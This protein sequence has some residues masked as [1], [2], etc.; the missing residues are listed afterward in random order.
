MGWTEWWTPDYREELRR[1]ISELQAAVSE[2]QAAASD[3]QAA[4]RDNLVRDN[5]FFVPAL[6]PG[7]LRMLDTEHSKPRSQQTFER[8]A[9][10]GFITIAAI[11]FAVAAVNARLWW[12]ERVLPRTVLSATGLPTG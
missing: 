9:Q 11:F 10:V 8:S 5:V 2:I 1:R 3:L 6:L 4:V 7:A 12:K